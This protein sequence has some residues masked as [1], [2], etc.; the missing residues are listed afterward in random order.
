LHLVSIFIADFTI[1][2]LM[3]Q[4]FNYLHWMHKCINA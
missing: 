2:L 3:Y 1:G 4:L